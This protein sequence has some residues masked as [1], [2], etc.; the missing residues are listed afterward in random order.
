M[1]ENASTRFE[2]ND[3]NDL[4]DFWVRKS[5]FVLAPVLD[6]VLPVATHCFSNDPAQT[7]SN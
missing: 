4:F 5:L 6:G 1:G 7:L 2:I 3:S